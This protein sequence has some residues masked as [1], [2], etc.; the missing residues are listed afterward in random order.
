M[1]RRAATNLG[2]ASCGVTYKIGALCFH[3]SP[4]QVDSFVLRNPLSRKRQTVRCNYMRQTITIL[5]LTISSL[6]VSGQ[7]LDGG[8]GHALILDKQGNVWTIGRNNFGQLGDSSLKNSPIPKKVKNLSNIV[9]ISRGY[10]HSIALNKNGNLFL[11]GRNNYGQLGCLSVNDQLTPQK[12]PIH[13]GFIAV[14]GGHLHTVGLKKDGTVWCWGHNYFAELGNG[15]REHSSS[16]VEVLQISNSKIS[17]LSHVVSIASVGYHTLALKK[18]GSVWGWGGNT[19]NELGK[20][21]EEFQ[22]YAIKVEGIP[23]IKE[24]AVGWHHSV[25]LDYNGDIWGWGSDPAFQFQE[26]TR[27]FYNQPTLLMGLPKFTKIAC[28]S[29][30]SLAIDENKNVWGWGKNHYGM[31]GTGDTISHSTPV[32]IKSLKNII[33]IGGGCFQSI[34]V[35]YSGKIFTFGDNPSGQLGIGNFSRCSS[36]KLMPLDIN[37][38]ISDDILALS[39]NSTSKTNFRA[40]EPKFNLDI[41]YKVIKYMLFLISVI[42]NIILY[43]KLKSYR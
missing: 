13:T 7:I 3:S 9:A 20:K 5:I 34:A 42:L 14:E 11:W 19:F 8:N 6:S 16:P 12:L 21:G 1:K 27:K 37:G 18:D 30:H 33:D 22:R 17:V 32:F 25:A 28:G 4:V 26:E 10:D 36:P 40:D 39:I 2:L 31:L 24:I 15:S 38:I 29:W 23:K 43:R 35:D 41:I